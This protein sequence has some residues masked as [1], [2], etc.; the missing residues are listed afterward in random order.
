[1]TSR[2]AE[3]ARLKPEF[4]AA[5]FSEAQWQHAVNV[6]AYFNDTNRLAFA[7]KMELEEGYEKS[8]G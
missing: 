1:M 3:A 8:C 6:V 2:P 7:M 4:L 5:G